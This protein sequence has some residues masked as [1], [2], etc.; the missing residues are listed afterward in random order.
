MKTSAHIKKGS[1]VV[2]GGGRSSGAGSRQKGEGRRG[3]MF[4]AGAPETAREGAYAPQELRMSRGRGGFTMIEIAISIGI[5][6]FALVAIIGILPSGLNV[7]REAHQDTTISQDAAFF[8]EAIRNGATNNG[9][10]TSQNLDFLTNYIEGIAVITTST[11]NPAPNGLTNAFGLAGN[12]PLT[13]GQQILGLLSTPEFVPDGLGGVAT[14]VVAARGHG[15]SGNALEQNGANNIVAF[16]Y[17]MTVEIDA[18]NTSAYGQS[19]SPT[20]Q[21]IVNGYLQRNLYDIRL[22]FAWPVI[23][24]PSSVVTGPGRQTY[25][26]IISGQ[27]LPLSNNV[28][29]GFWYFQPNSYSTNFTL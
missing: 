9:I 5:I 12:P 16:R 8:M 4:P 13:S 2:G 7:Q 26:S 22:K 10:V 11:A 18:M 29:S 15:L 3:K 21:P 25:R 6:G 27:L 20:F 14:N 23:V 24:T 1:S 19:N 17:F 28:T